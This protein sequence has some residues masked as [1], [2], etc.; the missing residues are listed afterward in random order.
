MTKKTKF[1][2]IELEFLRR[3]CKWLKDV[4]IVNIIIM[5]DAPMMDIEQKEQTTQKHLTIADTIVHKK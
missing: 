3:C 2:T 5:E 4:E 1:G